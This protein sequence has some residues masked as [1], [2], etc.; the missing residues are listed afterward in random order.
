MLFI[1]MAT[2]RGLRDG[3][4]PGPMFDFR[5]DFVSSIVTSGHKWIGAPM[6]CGVYLTQNKFRMKPPS[7]TP[8]YIGSPDTTFAGS[9]I[10]AF[11]VLFCGHTSVHIRTR[12]R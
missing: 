10:V 2:K 12:N 6:L 3:L 8:T 1:E 11:H 5:L 4:K 9:G 7:A